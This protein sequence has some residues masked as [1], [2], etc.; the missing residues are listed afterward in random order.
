[1]D[2]TRISRR[3][4]PLIQ[5]AETELDKSI[6]DALGEPLLHMVRNAIDHGLESP[7]ERRRVGKPETGRL[8]LSALYEGN[9]VHLVVEDDGRG[10]DVAQVARRAMALGL[11]DPKQVDT[12]PQAE[13]LNTIYQ[14]GFSTRESVSTVSGRGIGMDVVRRAIE[15]LKG[16]IELGT[17]PGQG[18]RFL[19]RL[20]LTLAIMRAILVE[21]AG[22][23]LCGAAHGSA[24]DCALNEGRGGEHP[25]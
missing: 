23:G 12:L 16:T 8:V 1:M 17:E 22:P 4:S 7:Q 5:G 20:P 13:L 14:P 11:A 6:V 9:H 15:N 24:G 21:A 2:E 19:I 25:R 10:L 18:T 3:V